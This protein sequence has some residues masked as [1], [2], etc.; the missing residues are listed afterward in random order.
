MDIRR[1]ILWMIFSF[2]LLLLWN[3]W[4]VYNGRPSLFGSG[5]PTQVSADT[6]SAT[7]GDTSVPTG[8]A[9]STDAPAAPPA[10]QL[11]SLEPA[12]AQSEPVT[13]TTDVFELTFDTLGAQLVKAQLNRYTATNA[14]DQPMVLFDR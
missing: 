4:Q 6:S 1:T 3:N 8:V 5:A 12:Q 14:A 11:E 7:A 10:E 9:A 13:V 2:S